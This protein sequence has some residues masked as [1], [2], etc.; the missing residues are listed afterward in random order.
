MKVRITGSSDPTPTIVWWY[1]KYIG[2][3]FTVEP[4][5]EQSSYYFTLI[6]G[7]PHKH[8]IQ[9]CDCEVIEEATA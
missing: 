4:D 7:S 1:A 6:P 3:V 8:H 2:E 9:K 5:P